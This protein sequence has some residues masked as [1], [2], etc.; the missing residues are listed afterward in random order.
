MEEKEQEEEDRE[1]EGYLP[2]LALKD[3]SSISPSAP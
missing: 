3:A 2:N 1:A